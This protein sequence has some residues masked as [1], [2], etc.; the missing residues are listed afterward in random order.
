MQTN[1]I[2]PSALALLDYLG[3]D[4]TNAWTLYR[5]LQGFE[6]LYN[7]RGDRRFTSLLV[8]SLQSQGLVEVR[9]SAKGM[10][11]RLTQNGLA[12]NSER[13]AAAEAVYSTLYWPGEWTSATLAPVP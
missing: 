13:E 9:R 5:D 7:R 11:L 4:P 2:D 6:V 1:A 12:S 8:R 10:Q 3:S